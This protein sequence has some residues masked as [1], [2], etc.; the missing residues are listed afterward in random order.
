MG[1]FLNK[2]VALVTIGQSENKG[3]V[4]QLLQRENNK[5]YRLHYQDCNLA[6]EVLF[7]SGGAGLVHQ[8]EMVDC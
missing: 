1:V 5:Q 4:P 2:N 7:V 6:P 8:F 3:R